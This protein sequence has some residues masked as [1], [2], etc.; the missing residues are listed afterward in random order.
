MLSWLFVWST[1]GGKAAYFFAR[2]LRPS[3]PRSFSME[4]R[5]VKRVG[6]V[7]GNTSVGG[8]EWLVVV[9]KRFRAVRVIWRRATQWLLERGFLIGAVVRK[10]IVRIGILGAAD[11]GV[12]WEGLKWRTVECVARVVGGHFNFSRINPHLDGI[13]RQTFGDVG[14]ADRLGRLHQAGV[15]GRGALGSVGFDGSIGLA[16]SGTIDV[17]VVTI[18]VLKWL[19]EALGEAWN[20]IGREAFRVYLSWPPIGSIIDFSFH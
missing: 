12:G 10:F 13:K 20:L 17:P 8:A 15:Y 3:N 11:G 16:A 4:V 6:I 5:L 1:R 14:N 19:F 18:L 9:G 2:A 7:V